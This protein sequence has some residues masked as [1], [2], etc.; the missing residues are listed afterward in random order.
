MPDRDLSP[1]FRPQ[2]NL[3][4]S[5]AGRM[6]LVSLCAGLAVCQ[7]ALS[8]GG[9]SLFI[10]LAAV[11][12][13]VLTELCIGWRGKRPAAR[14]GSAVASALVLSLLLPSH[15]HPV[16]AA[17]G[18]VFAM[19][20]VKYSFGGLGA[21]WLNPALGGWLFIRFSWPGGFESALESSPFALLRDSLGRGFTDPQGS[22]LG[23]L[24]LGGVP[25]ETPSF[26]GG[27]LDETLTALLN[28]TVFSVTGSEL[29]R[30]YIDLLFF[31]G[32]GIIADRGLLG[33]LLGTL[34]IA[35]FQIYRTWV[36]VAFLGVY[37]LLVRIFGGLPF[38]GPL[39][40]G[41]ILFGVLSGG[42]LPAAF[43]LAADP[44]TG[45]KSAPG[46]TFAA[47]LGGLLGF[48]FRYPGGEPY[49]AF[50]AAALV[51]TLVPLIRSLESRILYQ[52]RRS[53]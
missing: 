36:P 26:L 46:A 33:L 24:K 31:Q 15:L 44:A 23:I 40:S 49:G 1:Y 35:A 42:V 19:V 6:W 18:A 29:P 10:A 50:W 32:P 34:I 4:R 17:L 38:G 43:L 9:A 3:A 2:V 8:D 41:D 25:P 7:S 21:N 52:P 5:T 12:A 30:G 16:F 14:D 27:R 22:P 47:F 53:P 45:P 28:D 51:N 13:A 39:G 20:V 48:L 37:G 11:S